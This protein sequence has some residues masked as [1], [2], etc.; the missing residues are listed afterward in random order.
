MIFHTIVVH[1]PRVCHDLDPRLHL[2]FQVHSSHILST[3]NLYPGHNTL[4]PNWIWIIFHTIFVHDSRMCHDLDPRS[5][6]Q[7]THTHYSV[8]AMLDLD[9]ISHNCIMTLTRG[10]I[11]KVKVTVYTWKFFSI[12]L[13]FTGNSDE[14]D[15]SHNCWPWHRGCCC[16]GYLSR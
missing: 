4:L 14:D 13:P 16:G 11:A 10:L 12:P 6:S 7:C 3:Q 8:W 1:D 15:T 9:N 2:W 5:R